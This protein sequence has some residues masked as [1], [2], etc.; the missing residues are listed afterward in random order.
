MTRRRVTKTGK[1]DD[2]IVALCNPGSSWERVS[3][4]QAIK[5][6]EGNTNSYYVE[7]ALPAVDVRVVNGSN[8][9]YLRTTA[10]SSSKNNL[11]NLPDC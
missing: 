4:T 11:D 1:R 5:D 7:E 2:D 9:K 10:D 6:I 8:G 3:K